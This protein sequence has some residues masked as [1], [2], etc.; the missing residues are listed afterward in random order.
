MGNERVT[1]VMYE[2]RT[3]GIKTL[4]FVISSLTK[5][6]LTFQRDALG[7]VQIYRSDDTTSCMYDIVGLTSFGLECSSTPTVSARISHYIKWIEDIVWP[8]DA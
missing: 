4:Y 1:L 5:I 7:I 3:K 6:C 2:R 8:E